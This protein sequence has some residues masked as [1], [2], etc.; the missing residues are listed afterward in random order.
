[1]KEGIDST[2][3]LKFIP[4]QFEGY[5]IHDVPWNKNVIRPI[6]T[7]LYPKA[8]P[9]VCC[10]LRP[11]EPGQ[12]RCV[13][14][15]TRR[16]VKVEENWRKMERSLAKV[17]LD[18]TDPSE[19]CYQWAQ[20]YRQKKRQLQIQKQIDEENFINKNGHFNPQLNEHSMAIAE[21]W[22]T[23]TPIQ[24]RTQDL[25]YKR[26]EYLA[27][28]RKQ[29]DDAEVCQE[30]TFCPRLHPKSV[31]M[32]GRDL[33]SL[34][35]W[36]HRRAQKMS[37]KLTNQTQ[38]ELGKCP[39]TP[40]LTNTSRKIAEEYS[41]QRNVHDRLFEDSR[42][43]ELDY[44]QEQEIVK[45]LTPKCFAR[46]ADENV[47]S[48]QKPMSARSTSSP[49]VG[50]HRAWWEAQNG[51]RS[52]RALSREKGNRST[53]ARASMSLLPNSLVGMGSGALRS[54]KGFAYGSTAKRLS[55][56]S[57]SLD[58]D[59][60]APPPQKVTV[61]GGKNVVKLNANNSNVLETARIHTDSE[62]NAFDTDLG[63]RIPQRFA[64][65]ASL[66]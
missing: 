30:C 4:E 43:R 46:A 28:R 29:I 13:K 53:T 58:E 42:R 5:G 26:E 57:Y 15:G 36:D 35:R 14:C 52:A 11:F 18:N 6:S 16:P 49:A 50:S 37:T 2:T 22:K 12:N 1:M 54:K 19:R 21:Q 60:G 45:K 40:E 10:C 61:Y 41:V 62:Y 31:G 51:A 38:D 32:H 65:L 39:F 33:K 66:D 17:D 9:K 34:F 20:V 44:Y 55:S 27:M 24:D 48:G 7:G 8:T 56:R 64:L 63:G 47:K 59:A 3:S 23:Q 25:V